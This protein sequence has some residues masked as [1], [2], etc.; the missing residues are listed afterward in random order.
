MPGIGY[1]HSLTPFI[2]Q[3]MGK[4]LFGEGLQQQALNLSQLLQ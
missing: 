1:E 3:G 4:G 2:V